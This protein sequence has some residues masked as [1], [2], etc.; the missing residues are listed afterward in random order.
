[1]N[2]LKSVGRAALAAIFVNGGIDAVRSP[3]ARAR[4]VE[5]AGLPEPELLTRINGGVMA[6]AGVLMALGLAPRSMALALL[7]SLV[8]TTVVGHAF[9]NAQGAERQN[10]LVHFTK[11]LAMMGALLLVVADR[12]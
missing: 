11:N 8:P 12:E 9:W 4:M 7:G 3:A 6:G 2:L 10:Q 1:M 5:Q